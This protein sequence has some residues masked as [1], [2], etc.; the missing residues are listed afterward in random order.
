MDERLKKLELKQ[1]AP[2][3]FSNST[4]I[5]YYIPDNAGYAQIKI[6]DI[7]GS[8][9]KTF[10]AVNGE[11][12]INIGSSA[13]PAGTYNYTLYARNKKIDTKQMVITK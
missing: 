6:T 4:V 12:Q 2:N 1:N 7:R 8:L 5:S 11:G 9:I 3:P 13:L 10:N